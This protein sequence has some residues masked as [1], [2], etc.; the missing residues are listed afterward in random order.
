[1][2]STAATVTL[3]AICVLNLVLTLGMVRRLNRLT[4]PVGA[5]DAAAPAGARPA[6]AAP[7]VAGPGLPAPGTKV[8]DFTAV[9]TDGTTL[10]RAELTGRGLVAFFLTGCTSCHHLLPEFV[11]YADSFPGGRERVLAVVVTGKGGPDDLVRRLSPVARVTIE[12]VGGPVSTAFGVDGF[13]VFS[14]LQD[15]VVIAAQEKVAVLRRQHPGVVPAVN[16][17]ASGSGGPSTG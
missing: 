3:T 12:P 4:P 14:V 5:G 17:A 11:A 9:T 8:R 10:G 16:G 13:P 7:S 6:D 2:S 15:H 1:M